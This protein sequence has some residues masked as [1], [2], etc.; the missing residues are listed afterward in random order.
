MRSVRTRALFA[1]LLCAFF[2]LT[3]LVSHHAHAQPA[4]YPHRPITMVVGYPPGGST[5]LT[6]RVM[7]EEMSKLLK[8]TIVVENQGG[9]GGALAAQRVVK[10]AP[11][12]YTVML[13]SNN[14]LVVN[15]FVNKQLKVDGAKDFTH[16]GLIASQPL[17]FVATPK[18]GVKNIPEFLEAAKRNPGK[19][20]FGSA[21]IGTTLHLLGELIKDKAKVDVV[22]IPYKGVAPLATDLQGNNIE[23]GVFVLSS[24]LPHI[25]SGKVIALGISERKRSHLAPDIPS[26]SEHP[27]LADIDMGSWFMLSAPAGLPQPVAARL[28]TALVEALKSPEL[29]RRLEESGST[30]VTTQPDLASFMSTETQK[31]QRMVDIA[32][33]KP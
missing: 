5:D 8:T 22:H 24:G 6:A 28:R 7:A 27:A 3:T 13:A 15:Q 12:G 33:I 25:R 20:S 16:V 30:V 31:Y 14:E 17:V 19:F 10:S 32:G 26:L 29:R 18:A 1:S 11:D 23:Y 2:P 4:D 9:A 21:G